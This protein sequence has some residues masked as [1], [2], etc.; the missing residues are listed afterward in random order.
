MSDSITEITQEDGTVV[1]LTE[2][3]KDVR[4]VYEVEG[5]ISST[6]IARR[7]DGCNEWYPYDLWENGDGQ[8]GNLDDSSLCTGCAEQDAGSN[9]GSTM[10]RFV[11][12]EEKS[13]HEYVIFG[14]HMAYGCS[15]DYTDE[16]HEWFLDLLP[17]PWT[18]RRY[19]H[20]GGWRGYYDTVK[21][22]EGVTVVEN[23]WMTG[24]YSDVPW[25]RDTH[26]FLQAVSEGEV[27]PPCTFYVLFEPTSNV[28]STATDILCKDEDAE[29]FT[30]W[31][32]QSEY[33]LHRA[34]G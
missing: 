1:D 30:A 28:F 29:A 7:C 16:P 27:T 25:K 14:D 20:T 19:V 11:P 2:L 10:H 13:E 24:D 33:D 9:Y 26:T 4:D 5:D 6:S 23:G 32:E 15:E 34:L 3:D 22:L 8:W 17:K 21:V 18:G 12:G 31:L